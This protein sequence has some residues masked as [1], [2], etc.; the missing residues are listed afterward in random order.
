MLPSKSLCNSHFFF[1]TFLVGF[2]REGKEIKN[3]SLNY[4]SCPLW[5]LKGWP[6]KHIVSDIKRLNSLSYFREAHC[7]GFQAFHREI[8]AIMKH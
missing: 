3:F 2:V 1:I 4:I 6:F 7:S 5:G 8:L